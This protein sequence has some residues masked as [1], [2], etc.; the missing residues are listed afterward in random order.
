MKPT[1]HTEASKDKLTD[2]EPKR[3]NQR[4][5]SRQRRSTSTPAYPGGLG[6]LKGS[7]RGRRGGG[8]DGRDGNFYDYIGTGTLLEF[9]I[10]S[11]VPILASSQTA[12][13]MGF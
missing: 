4:D 3:F 7:R 9:C 12:A 13:H 1:T 11:R 6:P 5:F 2:Q 8:G 10:K